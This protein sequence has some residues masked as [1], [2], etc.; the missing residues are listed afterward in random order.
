MTKDKLKTFCNFKPDS[1]E[2]SDA[3]YLNDNVM[4]SYKGETVLELDFANNMVITMEGEEHIGEFKM[5][6]KSWQEVRVF[7]EVE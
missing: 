2:A 1:E 4:M 7:V 5:N 3:A 6:A